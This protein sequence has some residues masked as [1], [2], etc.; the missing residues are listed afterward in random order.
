ML[1][2]GQLAA[3][4]EGLWDLQAEGPA[5]CGFQTLLTCHLSSR[6]SALEWDQGADPVI[7]QMRQ[8]ECKTCQVSQLEGGGPVGGSGWPCSPTSGPVWVP[9]S[10]SFRPTPCGLD[11]RTSNCPLLSFVPQTGKS[12]QLG[13]LQ[14]CEA[15][16]S[17][18]TTSGRLPSPAQATSVD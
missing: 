8:T 12:G 3:L 14:D 15:S 9:Q 2:D 7:S 6:S 18:G 4:L 17:P 1:G 16:G 10:L 5:G 13:S 11:P